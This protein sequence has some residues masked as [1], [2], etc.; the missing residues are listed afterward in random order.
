MDFD[1]AWDAAS[2]GDTI[3]VKAG[4]YPAQ[5]ISGNGRRGFVQCRGCPVMFQAGGG[6]KRTVARFHSDEFRIAF[7]N[8]KRQ[9]QDLHS[10]RFRTAI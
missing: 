2:A 7:N 1:A 5:F 4:S 9:L 3:R 8:A 6:G 10:D